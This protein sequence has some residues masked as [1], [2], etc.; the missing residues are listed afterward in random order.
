MKKNDIFYVPKSKSRRLLHFELIND[1][2]YDN[3]SKSMVGL[4]FLCITFDEGFF[5][6]NLIVHS[7]KVYGFNV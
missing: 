1:L 6:S 4:D 5:K 3:V 7:S 2:D